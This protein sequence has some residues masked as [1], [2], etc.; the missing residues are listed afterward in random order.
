MFFVALHATG[1]VGMPTAHRCNYSD[2][3]C[4]KWRFYNPENR[5]IFLI[6]RV[7]FME[8][9]FLKMQNIKNNFSKNIADWR[10]ICKNKLTSS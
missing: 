1:M 10:L 2:I 5:P 7:S 6:P 3:K 8:D 4:R 9:I